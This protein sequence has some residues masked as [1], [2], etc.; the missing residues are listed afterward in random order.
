MK[1]GR[2]IFLGYFIL[3]GMAT[4]WFLYGVADQLRPSIRQSSEEALVD[5][6]NLLAELVAMEVRPHG[7]IDARLN[8]SAFSVALKRYQHRPLN[9]R[10]WTLDKTKPRFTIYVTDRDGIVVLHTDPAQLGQDYSQ[11]NDVRLTLAGQYG[12]RTTQLNE[13]DEFS[14]AM[15]VAAPIYHR[16]D[17][18]GSLTV[19]QPNASL[20][21]FI[22][23]ARQQIWQQGTIILLAALI[24]GALLSFWLTRSIRKLSSYVDEVSA[25]RRP[26]LPKIHERELAH[27]ADS[28][29]AMRESLEGRRYVEEYIHTLT[30]ELK[31]PL[32]AIRG[33]AELLQEA[34]MEAARRTRFLNNILGEA[35]RCTLLIERLLALAEVEKRTELRNAERLNLKSLVEAEIEAKSSRAQ[36]K[37]LQTRLHVPTGDCHVK[38]ERFLVAQAVSNLLDNAIDFSPEHAEIELTIDSPGNDDLCRISIINGGGVIPDYAAER[39]FE[40]FYSLPR[41]DSDRKSSGLGLSFVKEIAELHGGRIEISSDLS[42]RSVKAELYLPRWH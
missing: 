12:A 26:A 3:V 40:R 37:H 7:Q 10:I 30:H 15:Y 17:I 27:L 38:G 41:A 32:A 34:D 19:S 1:F 5:T 8:T 31:S 4:L 21:P 42:T 22:D 13:D 11:W 2:R 28:M 9:A 23:L 33:A 35:L 18:V 16:G 25:G 24:L 14:T 39:I 20:Q 36:L 29:E 6:A